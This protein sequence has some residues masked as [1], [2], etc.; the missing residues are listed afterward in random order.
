[1]TAVPRDLWRPSSGC[2][3]DC[4]PA[5]GE[6]PTVPMARRVLRLVAS[7]SVWSLGWHR[8]EIGGEIVVHEALGILD[9]DRGHDA[10]PN[11]RLPAVGWEILVDKVPGLQGQPG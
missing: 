5:A 9:L 7:D 6:V 4:L 10:D 3:D 8:D 2:G 1:M 11:G